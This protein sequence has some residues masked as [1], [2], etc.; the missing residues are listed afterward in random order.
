ME[1]ILHNHQVFRFLNNLNA[2]MKVTSRMNTRGY[3]ILPSA[4]PALSTCIYCRTLVAPPF[5][6]MPCG[7]ALPLH[8][9]CRE[10]MM[11]SEVGCPACRTFWNGAVG[12][13]ATSVVSVPG[14]PRM[15]RRNM[16]GCECSL[17]WA[18]YG[19]FMTIFGAVIMYL[20]I[21]YIVE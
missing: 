14:Q 18:G 11:I 9:Q 15:A 17:L 13:S 16:V 3:Q 10:T 5:A 6:H 20:M 21:H 1:A 8:T 4:P 19:V 12:S 7:C 2:Q